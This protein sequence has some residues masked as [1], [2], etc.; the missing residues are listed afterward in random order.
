MKLAAT[1]T[2]SVLLCL[3]SGLSLA[4]SP[5][6]KRAEIRKM[7]AE[8]LSMLYKR[9]PRSK[10]RI[11]NAY[12]YAVFS[13]VGVNVILLSVA[14]GRGVAHENKT[15]KDVYMKMLSGGVGP[16]LGVKDFRGV[17]VFENQKVFDR[18]VRRGWEGGAQANAVAKVDGRGGDAEA[19]VTVAPGIK[20]YQITDTGLALEATLQGTK[21]FKDDDLNGGRK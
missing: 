2:I 5:A 4:E 12:G 14:G 17:F 9:Q 19:V 11:A 16:G 7:R 6:Q 3:F 15:G 18:F 8:A 21:Y 13:N 10:A 20:F 1:F